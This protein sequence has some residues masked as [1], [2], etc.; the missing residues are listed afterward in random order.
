VVGVLKKY[1]VTS[2]SF[3]LAALTSIFTT[4]GATIGEPEL[5]RQVDER[6]APVGPDVIRRTSGPE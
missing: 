5:D 3:D 2:V 6:P 4:V 1:P